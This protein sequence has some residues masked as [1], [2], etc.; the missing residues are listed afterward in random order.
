MAFPS[1]TVVR[2]E[3]VSGQSCGHAPTTVVRAIGFLRF[4]IQ[5]GVETAATGTGWLLRICGV[6]FL[7]CGRPGGPDTRE[8]SGLPV[9]CAPW[10]LQ[11]APES[12]DAHVTFW[13]S[14]CLSPTWSDLG[15]T[16]PLPPRRASSM[17]IH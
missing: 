2:I 15:Q 6:L 17:E 7:N 10:L 11:A 3:Q 8:R 14:S 1:S 16:I 5:R 13:H 4:V 12:M 9:P